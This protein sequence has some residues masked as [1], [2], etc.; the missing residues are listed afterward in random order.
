MPAAKKMLCPKCGAEMNHHADKLDFTT[1]LSE[2]EAVDPDFGG[3]LEEVHTCPKCKNI[4]VRRV[5]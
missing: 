1:A 5:S 2:P 4:E 3:I